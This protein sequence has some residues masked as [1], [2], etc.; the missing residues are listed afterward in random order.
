MLALLSSIISRLT[1]RGG[2]KQLD[3]SSGLSAYNRRLSWAAAAAS[4]SSS[5]HEDVEPNSMDS[6]FICMQSRVR[7]A[8]SSAAFPLSFFSLSLPTYT[9]IQCLS[10]LSSADWQR[11]CSSFIHSMELLKYL[12]LRGFLFTSLRLLP[13]AS[14]LSLVCVSRSSSRQRCSLN[15]FH[16]F[17]PPVVVVFLN[18]TDQRGICRRRAGL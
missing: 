7:G 4:A 6:V 3:V 2:K 5:P 13:C 12:A 1:A 14:L 11:H 9:H 15:S 17:S 8:G 18:L 16:L 10:F